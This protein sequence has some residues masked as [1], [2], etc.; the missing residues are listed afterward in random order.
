MGAGR[1]H[2]Q[3]EELPGWVFR[4]PG[5]GGRLQCGAAGVQTVWQRRGVRDGIVCDMHG[6]P[7]W[8]L[9]GGG[10]HGPM[11]VLPG[12]HL[13]RG[14]RLY[15]AELLP[16]LPGQVIDGIGRSEQQASMRLRQGVLSHHQRSGNL[17]RV[18]LVP[19]VP[20]GSSVRRGRRVR[21]QKRRHRLQLHRRD[22]QHRG[23]VGARQQ[24]WPV[25]A[26]VVP[27]RVRDEDSGG[28]RIRRSSGV[29]QVSVA[30]DL[31]P[32]P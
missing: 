24:Q 5:I 8:V 15:R 16:E 12:K 13:C 23:S 32:E 2:L 10:E 21:P 3:I 6:M 18:A 19:D 9:Q 25:P 28:A 17:G 29:L 20:Q 22:Q 11:C 14:R 30:L 27:C 7:S 1:S 4:V 26:H 31:H